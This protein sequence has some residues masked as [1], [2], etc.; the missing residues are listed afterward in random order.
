MPDEPTP[1]DVTFDAPIG[2]DIKSETWSCVEVPNSAELLGTRKTVRV[3]ASVD[4]VFLENVGLLVT[5]AGGH[6]LSL[7]AKVRR[8]LAKDIGDVVTVRLQSRPAT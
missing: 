6:M 7:S 3:D 4:G 5:G 1:L 8:Q 2:V